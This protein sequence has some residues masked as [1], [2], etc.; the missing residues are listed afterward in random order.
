MKSQTKTAVKK[1]GCTAYYIRNR[2]A[3]LKKKYGISEATYNE[4]LA[5]GNGACWICKR[6]P[7]PGR[8]LNV[9][10]QHLLKTER[11]AGATFGKVRGLLCY[12]CNKYLVGRRK[13]EHAVLFEEAAR[14]LRSEKDWRL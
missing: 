11:K 2:D 4:M 7:L 9:D 5:Y 3:Y 14:Y 1:A 6:K 13:T 10:H 8:N 12:M